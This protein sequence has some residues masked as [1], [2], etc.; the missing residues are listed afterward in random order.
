MYWFVVFFTSVILAAVFWVILTRKWDKTAQKSENIYWY[1]DMIRMARTFDPDLPG[2]DGYMDQKFSLLRHSLIFLISSVALYFLH[3]GF[4][5]NCIL[6][7][8]VLY[9]HLSISRYRYRMRECV[10]AKPIEGPAKQL[11]TAL[12]KDSFTTVIY[13]VICA[14]SLFVLLY[15]R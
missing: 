15:L 13:S 8:N 3:S 9:A 11:R 14:F 1:A 2:F 5:E 12:V 4:L 7:V 6:V 10:Q